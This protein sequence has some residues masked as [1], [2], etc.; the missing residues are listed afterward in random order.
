MYAQ[1]NI[2]V[3]LWGELLG[4][5]P[6]SKLEVWDEQMDENGR[7]KVVYYKRGDEVD[8]SL[9]RDADWE[10][11]LANGAIGDDAPVDEFIDHPPIPVGATEVTSSDGDHVMTSASSVG[12]EK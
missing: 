2:E 10:S 7:Q 12:G 11:L 3:P 6:R 8:K 1:A 5:D 4:I 9:F